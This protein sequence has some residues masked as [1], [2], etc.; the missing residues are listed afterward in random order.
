MDGEKGEHKL[1]IYKC[2]IDSE[3]GITSAHF[4]SHRLIYINACYGG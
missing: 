2:R 4:T 1:L 3:P